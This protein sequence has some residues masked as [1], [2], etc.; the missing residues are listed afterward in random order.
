[1]RSGDPC[2]LICLA[3]PGN[4]FP[5]IESIGSDELVGKPIKLGYNSHYAIV[6]MDGQAATIADYQNQ[7]ELFDE[8]VIPQETQAL[9]M[10][11]VELQRTYVDERNIELS[12]R[13]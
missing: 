12:S 3:L 10:F 9:P 8:L 1:M 7:K 2:F 6:T 11:I 5:A 13:V 4:V